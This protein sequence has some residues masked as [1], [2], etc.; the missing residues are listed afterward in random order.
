MYRANQQIY[1]LVIDLLWQCVK[2]S[3]KSLISRNDRVHELLIN[4]KKSSIS[5]VFEENVERFLCLRFSITH[6]YDPLSFY[7][8]S[9]NI[10]KKERKKIKNG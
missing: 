3:V 8:Y 4:S 5:P 7:Y 9:R 10:D 1:Y 6:T 2:N